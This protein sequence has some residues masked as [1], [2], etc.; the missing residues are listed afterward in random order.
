M[1]AA[2]TA[3]SKVRI[4]PFRSFESRTRIVS[5]SGATSTQE[6]LLLLQ[7]RGLID[8]YPL[9]HRVE[10]FECP[11]ALAVLCDQVRIYEIQG[12]KMCRPHRTHRQRKKAATDV[13]RWPPA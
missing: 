8:E 11:Y 1:N 6:P 10:S 2:K 5:L 4:G 12:R 7:R 9:R 3:R 13:C